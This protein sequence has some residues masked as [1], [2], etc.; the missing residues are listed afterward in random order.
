M[1][2]VYIRNPRF[3]RGTEEDSHEAL[4]CLLDGLKM[5]EIDVSIF[6]YNTDPALMVYLQPE[7][8]VII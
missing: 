4:R 8:E 6:M 3:G 5:E 1:I 2:S 7:I